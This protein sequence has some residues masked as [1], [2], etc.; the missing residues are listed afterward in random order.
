LCLRPMTCPHHCLIFQQETRSYRD[1]PLRWCENSVLHRYEA[2]GGLKG[3]ER[4]RWFEIPDHH[5]FVASEPEQLKEE[6]KNNY[7][8]IEE[9]L[10]S[11]NFSISRRVCSL[12]D[13]Q[14]LSKY[15]P[16]KEL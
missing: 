9:I 12:H 13:P 15:H 5:I 14:N 3:L 11:F 2:S 1:L 6:F 16:D 4:A 10:T 7:R 8:Y